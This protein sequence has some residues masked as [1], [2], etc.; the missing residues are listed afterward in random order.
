MYQLVAANQK[1]DILSCQEQDLKLQD[2]IKQDSRSSVFLGSEQLHL[3]INKEL[4][5][6][7]VDHSTPSTVAVIDEENPTIPLQLNSEEL[8]EQLRQDNKDAF[9]K[10]CKKLTSSYTINK[11]N[12]LLY[13]GCLEV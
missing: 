5:N 6:A 9:S 12:L 11:N 1:A 2:Q 3:L 13:E 4:G 8:L 10:I 7:A